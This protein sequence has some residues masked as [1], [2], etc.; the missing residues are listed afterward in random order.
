KLS[1]T[2]KENKTVALKTLASQV[3]YI[4]FNE[5][6]VGSVIKG[7][8]K[9]WRPSS[10]KGFAPTIILEAVDGET[11]YGMSAGKLTKAF[12]GDAD[13]NISPSILPGWWVEVKYLGMKEMTAG[14]YKG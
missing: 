10:K 14:D 7:Y 5:V 2:M 6:E 9:E 4:D 1:Q 13:K 8:Y 3:D 12:V 11:L